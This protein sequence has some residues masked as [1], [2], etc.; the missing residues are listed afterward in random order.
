MKGG[1][2]TEATRPLGHNAITFLDKLNRLLIEGDS[3]YSKFK[4]E[5]QSN[6][7]PSMV[8]SL[9]IFENEKIYTKLLAMLHVIGQMYE[10]NQLD[11][12]SLKCG[13]N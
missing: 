11:I 12:S 1:E 7:K 10:G 4:F 2:I 6:F 9:G 13:G 8:N 5:R 3:H